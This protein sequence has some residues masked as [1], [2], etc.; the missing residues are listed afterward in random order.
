MDAG[1]QIS[2]RCYWRD[3]RMPSLRQLKN[4]WSLTLNGAGPD[5]RSR[6]ATNAMLCLGQSIRACT[7]NAIPI[8]VITLV[9][10]FGSVYVAGR[11]AER[12]GRSFKNWACIA[13]FLLDPLALP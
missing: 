6:R 10:I 8:D 3:W 2:H 11:I 1:Q 7:V 9:V 4:G 12:R 5:G 13:G